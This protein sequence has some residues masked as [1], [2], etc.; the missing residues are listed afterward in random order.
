M[1]AQSSSIIIIIP[2]SI[3]RNVEIKMENRESSAAES[4]PT[5]TLSKLRLTTPASTTIQVRYHP[6]FFSFDL[7][8]KNVRL[9]ATVM[10][11]AA[12]PDSQPTIPVTVTI[13]GL[14]GHTVP[15]SCASDC[16]THVEIFL[17]Q[18]TD[19]TVTSLLQ[20]MIDDEEDQTGDD[21]GTFDYSGLGKTATSW[22]L[23]LT[24]TGAQSI[25]LTVPHLPVDT[26]YSLCARFV[27]LRSGA[28]VQQREYADSERP[29]EHTPFMSTDVLKNGMRRLRAGILIP[30]REVQ[31]QEL[32]AQVQVGGVP[33]VTGY[34][35][36]DG[37]LYTGGSI[38]RSIRNADDDLPNCTGSDPDGLQV[39]VQGCSQ[40]CDADPTCNA[41]MTGSSVGRATDDIMITDTKCTLFSGASTSGSDDFAIAPKWITYSKQ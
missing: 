16:V 17:A 25:T 33:S 38:I 9:Y 15:A 8:E 11:D 7:Y 1:S 28:V 3:L 6:I 24:S 21:A 22:Y 41:F 32:T 10:G 27:R 2:M 34:R 5:F 29:A 18:E 36:F 31:T 37:K 26:Y 40:L 39:C 13:S 30:K 23:D 20:L 14:P 4:S 12:V 19:G 35:A